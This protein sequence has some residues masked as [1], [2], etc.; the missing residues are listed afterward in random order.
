METRSRSSTGWRAATALLTAL[1]LVACGSSGG[2]EEGAAPVTTIETVATIASTTTTSTTLAATT[3]TAR[4]VIEVRY[5]VERRVSDQATADFET[6]VRATLD[7]PRGWSRAR[8][9]LAHDPGADFVVVLAEGPE[10]DEL[11]RPYDTYGKYSCQI[12]PVVARHEEP[13][14]PPF[15]RR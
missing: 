15:E 2:G 6:V 1:T 5:R 11:C 3:T 9:R 7:D 12:G 13:L 10:V 4:P 8:F 14:A